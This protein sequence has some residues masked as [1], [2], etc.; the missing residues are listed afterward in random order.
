MAD[1]L[2]SILSYAVLAIV[3]FSGKYDDLN[4]T[5]LSVLIS[6]NAFVT[7]YLIFCFTRLIDLATQIADIA[8][9][10]HR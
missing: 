10:T 7:I 1:Y 5:E 2:G 3:I 8:G 6:Q 9:T 4:A